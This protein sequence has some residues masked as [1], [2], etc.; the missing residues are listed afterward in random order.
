MLGGKNYTHPSSAIAD[1]P[2]LHCHCGLLYGTKSWTTRAYFSTVRQEHGGLVPV[3]PNP[4]FSA[5]IESELIALCHQSV[6]ENVIESWIFQANMLR[7]AGRS[8]LSIMTVA[9]K[10]KPGHTWT[11]TVKPAIAGSILTL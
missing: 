4:M 10:G 2:Y 8:M 3:C 9:Y 1:L 7:S 11:I 5:A 6:L